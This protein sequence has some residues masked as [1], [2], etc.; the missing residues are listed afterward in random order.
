MKYIFPVVF[1]F[2]IS[3][4][5]TP[6]SGLFTQKTPHERYGQALV[7]AGLDQSVLGLKWFSA[8][9]SGLTSPLQVAV[10]YSEKGF[11]DAA[12]P[13]AVGLR[14]P[15]REGEKIQLQLEKKPASGFQLFF[16][17]WELR[18]N[19]RPPKLIKAADSTEAVIDHVVA[20]SGRYLVRLQPE[21]LGTGEYQLSISSGPS[22]AYPID[23]PGKNHIKS[24][25][26]AARDGGARSHEGIDLFAARLTP[27]VAAA[28]GRV[29][30][31]NNNRL[32]GKV[33]WMQPENTNYS[34][35]YA[36]LDSQLVQSGQRVS[37]GDTLGL[38][39]NTGNARTTAPH[40]HFGI[41]TRGGAVDPLPFVNP[42]RREPDALPE[43]SALIDTEARHFSVRSRSGARMF[44]APDA[45]SEAIQQIPSG[46]V[47]QVRSFNRDWYRIQTPDHQLGFIPR[48]AL[49]SASEP[50]RTQQLTAA[51]PLLAKPD[52]ISPHKQTLDPGQ[53]VKILGQF[54]SWYFVHTGDNLGW[55]LK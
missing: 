26:G 44:I 50:L 3:G 1:F 48:S 45:K 29:T 39:G 17:L 33:V 18:D 53:Q 8:A 47:L 38:M 15:V 30:R 52:S 51:T 6:G 49:I 34:L 10:P 11:F 32:G 4:C 2:V 28:D 36:H 24:F 31:V 21:L 37:T 42:Q 35:Y 43:S 55:I 16:E 27:V 14:F 40:L 13:Q 22:L 54:S 41:Y 5:S 23:A 46:T 12:E 19:D 7:Q 9:D 25:W 20:A